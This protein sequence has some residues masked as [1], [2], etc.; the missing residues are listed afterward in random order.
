MKAPFLIEK[1]NHL[2][3]IAFSANFIF[4]LPVFSSHWPVKA[5]KTVIKQEVSWPR[6]VAPIIRPKVMSITSTETVL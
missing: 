4:M 6:N 3:C 2:Y 1:I 5:K